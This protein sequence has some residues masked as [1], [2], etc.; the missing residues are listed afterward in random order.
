MTE[1]I[2]NYDQLED[3]LFTCR[4][5]L[6]E[7]SLENLIYPCKCTGSSKYVHKNCLNEW[8]N[9]TSNN[10]N[11]HKCEICNHVYVI[12][13]SNE[14]RSCFVKTILSTNCFYIAMNLVAFI[15]S[16]LIHLMDPNYKII[17]LF[18]SN[19]NNISDS[20]VNIIYW[21]ISLGISIIGLII[22]LCIGLTTIRNPKLYCK[23]YKNNTLSFLNFTVLIVLT[24]IIK[25]YNI[26][27]ILIEYL[28]YNISILHLQS[29]MKVRLSNNNEIVNY[30]DSENGNNVPVE[31]DSLNILISNDND[32]SNC[33]EL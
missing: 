18:I 6:E 19:P 5:C 21:I 29:I 13:P 17:G 23:L 22:Y 14:N 30:E 1:S 20:D 15:L 25:F 31:M 2:I 27:V 32:E 10:D 24:L 7:D 11:K 8:R 3:N 33:V 16:Q 26:A 12:I 4:I 9:I 28:I